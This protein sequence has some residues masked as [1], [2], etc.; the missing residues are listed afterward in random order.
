MR[1]SR[2]RSETLLAVSAVRAGLAIAIESVGADPLIVKGRRDVATASDLAVEDA[3][4]RTLGD[5]GDDPI[6]GE[7]RGG[8]AP[9]DGSS[10]WLID[11]ICGTGN[12]A[13]GVPL[14]CVNLA[15]VEGGEVVLAAVGEPSGAIDVAERGRG[16][17][18][19]S[20][21]RWSELR[22]SATS[23]TVMVE[24]GRAP[25]QRRAW[26]A[27]TLAATA[28]ADR[29]DLLAL[30]STLSLAHVAAGRSSAYVLFWGS[31]L[32]C[33]AGVALVREAG[34]IVTDLDGRPWTVAS[35]SVVAV[36][37]EGLHRELIAIVRATT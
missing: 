23:E 10:Y 4:R 36:A 17:W 5:G 21:D 9:A 37:D 31:A 16:A 27:R 13:A 32:H 24:V 11:P 8:S 33:G 34:G 26:A 19:T 7:E 14:Y 25:A 3:I 12:F 28:D 2:L 1:P 35:E 18:S 22:T 29:W 20:D 15:F 6:V 30:G